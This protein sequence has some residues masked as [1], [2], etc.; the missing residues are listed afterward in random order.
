MKRFILLTTL[1][2][3]LFINQIFAKEVSTIKIQIGEEILN[4]ELVN[5]ST[6][7]ELKNRLTKGTITLNM[8][9]YGNMEKV[10]DFEKSLPTNDEQISTNTG[11]ITLYQG[12]SL[13]IYY[14]KNTWNLTRI[15]KIKNISEDELK[16]ILGKKSIKVELYLE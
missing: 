8:K 5:N 3:L 7:V 4:V 1:F 9:D 10:G 15:G 12:K 2:T 6:T 14:G 11:D 13:A 16:K